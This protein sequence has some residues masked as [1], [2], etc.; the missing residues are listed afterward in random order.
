MKEPCLLDP[1]LPECAPVDGMCK[2]GWAMNED[3]QCFPRHDRCP[4]GHHS[5]EDDESGRCIPNDTPCD[6]GYVINPHFPECGKKERI[7]AE[8]PVAK[9]CGG[10]GGRDNDGG[11]GRDDN[12]DDKDLVIKNINNHKVIIQTIRHDRN[13]FP[14]IDII[15]L[16][17]KGDNGDAMVCLMNIGNAVLQC[18]DFDILN[19]RVG[20]DFSKVVELSPS[21]EYDNGNTGSRAILMA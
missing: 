8:H 4:K 21:K 15:G 9:V 13:T 10:K 5:H 1:P 20:A 14:D 17:V 12:D 19:D 6:P 3:G 16:S 7:C 2:E 11:S 18:Q